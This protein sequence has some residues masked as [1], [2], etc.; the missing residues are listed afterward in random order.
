MSDTDRKRNCTEIMIIA[1]HSFR[2]KKCSSKF[3]DFIITFLGCLLICFDFDS[4][5]CLHFNMK[6]QGLTIS[7][8]IL[9]QCHLDLF[10]KWGM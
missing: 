2:K 7:K 8:F 9:K 3:M 10:S 1:A 6:C 5:F 4:F